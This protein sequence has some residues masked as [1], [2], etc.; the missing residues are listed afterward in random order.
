LRK[1]RECRSSEKQRVSGEL[2]RVTEDTRGLSQD[3]RNRIKELE[4]T[5]GRSSH[6]ADVNVKRTQTAS[7]KNRFVECIQRYSSVE[8]AHRA[9]SKQRMAKQY[10]VI[11]PNAS[12]E[13][14]RQVLENPEA[15]EAMFRQ[16]VRPFPL[17]A[18]GIVLRTAT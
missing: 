7:V 14:V 16:A 10:K 13:E 4:R 1:A 2:S 9:S 6:P 15:S 5:N 17:W 8:A 3:L 12:D 18:E 11:N